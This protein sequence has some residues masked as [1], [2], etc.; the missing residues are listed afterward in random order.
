LIV[1]TD[2]TMRVRRIGSTTVV[3]SCVATTAV[4]KF[5]TIIS[6]T[7]ITANVVS[8]RKSLIRIGGVPKVV[9]IWELFSP[10]SVT[11]GTARLL[12]EVETAVGIVKL[13]LRRT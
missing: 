13:H 6:S 1:I 7:T 5:S 3:R 9:E 2:A 12:T 11:N 8:L 10:G 4:S